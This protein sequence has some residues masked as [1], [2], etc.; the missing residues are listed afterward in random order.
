MKYTYISGCTLPTRVCIYL[1]WCWYLVM[2]S[3]HEHAFHVTSPLWGES[4]IDSPHKWPVTRALIFSLVLA[5]TSGWINRRVAG[6]LKRYD[7]HCDVIVMFAPIDIYFIVYGWI[8]LQIEISFGS[9]SNLELLVSDL[10]QKCGNWVCT[11]KVNGQD[12]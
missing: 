8:I 9:P 2:M 11:M 1:I 3:C 4:L 6:D 12:N 10:W 5:Q 7:T